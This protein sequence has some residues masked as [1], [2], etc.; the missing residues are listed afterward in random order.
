MF[1]AGTN[2]SQLKIQG[3]VFNSSCTA[4]SV[5]QDPLTDD[6]VMRINNGSHMAVT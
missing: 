4:E 1:K 5:R 6:D 3:S 2:L